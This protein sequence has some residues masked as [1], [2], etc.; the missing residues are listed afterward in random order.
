MAD[1][2]FLSPVS[3]FRSSFLRLQ[4]VVPVPRSSYPPSRSGSG[5]NL[6]LRG[7]DPAPALSGEMYQW[8]QRIGGGIGGRGLFFFV[9][10]V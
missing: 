6:R 1:P 8:L 7:A 2:M 4:Y 3:S 9:V 5:S 10:V